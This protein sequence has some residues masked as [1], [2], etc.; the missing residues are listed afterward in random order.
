MTSRFN[1]GV[2][3]AAIIMLAALIFN[4]PLLVHAQDANTAPDIVLLGRQES[5]EYSNLVLGETN[6][7]LQIEV[8]SRDGKTL[9]ARRQAMIEA[10]Y[11]AYKVDRAQFKFNESKGIFERIAPAPEAVAP[12]ANPGKE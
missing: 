8:L 9:E 7:Q 3:V 10:L 5:A 2:L 12:K 1:I 6:I 4:V 11:V